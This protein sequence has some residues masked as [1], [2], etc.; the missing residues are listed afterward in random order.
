MFFL[1]LHYVFFNLGIYNSSYGYD[2]HVFYEYDVIDYC[3]R[4]LYVTFTMDKHEPLLGGCWFLKT[5]LLSA[6][7]W[8][9]I[10]ALF[11]K[12]I[13]KKTI[14]ISLFVSLV[15]LLISKYYSLEFPYIGN[16]SIIFMGAVFYLIGY[17]YHRIEKRSFYKWYWLVFLSIV[18]LFFTHYYHSMSM[19]CNFDDVLFYMLIAFIGIFCS[20]GFC[21]HLEKCG[22]GLYVIGKNTMQILALHF[23]A[24]KIVSIG[25]VFCFNLPFE[26]LSEFPVVSFH[27][28]I[29]WV[30]YSL[31]GIMVPLLVKMGYNK[32]MVSSL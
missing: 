4:L 2:G 28:E 5:L 7:F 27:Q 16:L 13:S 18:L 1:L 10:L 29:T 9:V 32:L 31:V 8:R 24:F 11:D 21:Y 23:L 14:G 17:I 3:K 25:V 20:F 30:V 15:L 6:V 26:R 19:H 12:L 22:V